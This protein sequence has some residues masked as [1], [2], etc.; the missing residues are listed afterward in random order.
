M[1]CPRPKPG[2]SVPPSY[3][4]KERAADLIDKLSIRPVFYANLALPMN[5]NAIFI[6]YSFGSFLQVASYHLLLRFGG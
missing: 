5:A 2:A 1:K 3:N 6:S 4:W